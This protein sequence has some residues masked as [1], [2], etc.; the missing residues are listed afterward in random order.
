MNA[1]AAPSTSDIWTV[2]SKE[3]TGI[4]L[5]WGA[6]EQMYFKVPLEQGVASLESDMP[7]LFRLMQT[8]MMESLL[9]RMSLL[10]DP[11]VSGKGA[12]ERTNVSLARLAKVDE[13][14]VDVVGN[15][16]SMWDTSTLRLIRDKYLSHNDLSRAKTQAHTLNIP[17]SSPNIEAMREL[18]LALRA[19]R[20]DV[21]Q[22]LNGAAYLDESV[23]MELKRDVEVLSRSL[24]AGNCFYKLL[25]DHACL[26]DALDVAVADGTPNS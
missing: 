26:Q 21:H 6:L 22:K 1:P 13:R 5:L 19:F 7:L 18:I 17:L 10:M 25:P 4:Q 12:G 16:H 2:I 24:I 11:A 15:V 20:R 9:M 8:A 3:I 23:S 14:F